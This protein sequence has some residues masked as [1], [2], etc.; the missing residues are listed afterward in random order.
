MQ[1]VGNDFI[2]LALFHLKWNTWSAEYCISAYLA[3]E[4]NA[5]FAI[6]FDCFDSRREC[7]P[8]SSLVFRITYLQSGVFITILNYYTIMY[9]GY[10][11]PYGYRHNWKS[12]IRWT[13]IISCLLECKW[14]FNLCLLSF[15][16]IVISHHACYIIHVDKVKIELG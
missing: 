11:H 16:W 15:L 2:Y 14:S 10:L 7:A 5:V 4:Q 3:W 13:M 9:I 6:C 12:N 1:K 8:S